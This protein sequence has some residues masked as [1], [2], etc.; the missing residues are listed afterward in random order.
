[1]ENLTNQ[2]IFSDG[3]FVVNIYNEEGEVLETATTIRQESITSVIDSLKK[4]IWDK[5]KKIF[6]EDEKVL[7]SD[8]REIR[9]ENG[10]SI[11]VVDGLFKTDYENTSHYEA[12]AK[13][14]IDAF[15]AIRDEHNLGNCAKLAKAGLSWLSGAI[16][17]NRK[18]LDDLLDK[19]KKLSSK[20]EDYFSNLKYSE[21][22]LVGLK[23]DFKEM[24]EIYNMNS[25]TFVGGKFWDWE[26]SATERVDGESPTQRMFREEQAKRKALKNKA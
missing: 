26:Y 21:T 1:M 15:E 5:H 19:N 18:L 13:M 22:I 17:G 14:W 4:K 6:I 11:R 16:V 25:S 12:T 23:S 2:V 9:N 3:K 20:Q 8:K 24:E 10:E 7:S